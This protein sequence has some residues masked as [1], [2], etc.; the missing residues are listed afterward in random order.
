M[1]PAQGQALPR[2]ELEEGV[3][4]LLGIDAGELAGAAESGG[5][6]PHFAAELLDGLADVLGPLAGDAEGLLT[7]A[8]P[9]ADLRD[10]PIGP[11]RRENGL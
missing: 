5:I 1:A 8:V 2:A 11:V 9:V 7:P 4:L 3:Q 10:D 6:G